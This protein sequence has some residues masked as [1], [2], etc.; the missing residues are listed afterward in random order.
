[1]EFGPDDL[2]RLLKDIA[3]EDLMMK[4]H[5]AIGLKK[6]FACDGEIPIIPM[7]APQLVRKL[8]LLAKD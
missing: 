5:G 4:L 1:M 8:L 6:I 3:T 2:D 7:Q